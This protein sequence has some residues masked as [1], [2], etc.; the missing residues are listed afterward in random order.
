MGEVTAGPLA[1]W[2]DGPARRAVLRFADEAVTPGAPGF[3]APDRRVAVFDC[4]GTLWCERPAYVQALFVLDRL[5]AAARQRPELVDEPAA[6]ELLAG[7]LA[8]ALAH[9]L[10]AV[11]ALL[12]ATH[13]GMTAEEFAADAAAWLATSRHP[14]FGTPFA[15]TAYRP[16]VE[17][18]DLLRAR[19]FRVFI[20]TGGGVEFVR[21]VAGE[22]FGVAPEDVVGSAVR[23]AFAHRDGRSVLVRRAEMLGSP[24]EGAP[25]PIRIQ[26]HI[27][28]RP[29][30][31]VGNSAGDREMLEYVQDGDGPS[32]CV[33]VDHDDAE[34]EY[35]YPGASLTD[36]SAE[37]ILDTAG[38]RGWTVVSMATDWARV[39]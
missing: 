13:A 8:G 5:R 2:R 34:R 19:G 27:G 33:V 20:V 39:F 25:K 7:D 23:L 17:M 4:D 15:G 36:P 30:V 29:S 12:L 35:A 31:A 6:R 26:E 18:A 21:A 32:L 11:A 38:R 16:M 28:R 22:A 9:G 1:S 37:P 14:R 10:E 3:V 24:N